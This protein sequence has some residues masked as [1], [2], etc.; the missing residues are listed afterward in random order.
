[1][2][3]LSIMSLSF[4]IPISEGVNG[5][6]VVYNVETYGKGLCSGELSFMRRRFVN[7]SER[8]LFDG[9]S[10]IRANGGLSTRS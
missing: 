10:T 5:V 8:L 4:I 1:M 3:L 2:V 6:P 7:S 9:Y